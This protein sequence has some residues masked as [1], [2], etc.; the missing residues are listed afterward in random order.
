MSPR[1]AMTIVSWGVHLAG[2]AQ[3]ELDDGQVQ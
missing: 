2:A 1:I 3:H